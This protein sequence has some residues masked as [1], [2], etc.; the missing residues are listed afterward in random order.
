MQPSEIRA[1][2]KP[3]RVLP[4]ITVEDVARTVTLSRTLLEAGMPAVELTL[5]TPAA[6]EGI[7]A[8]KAEVPGLLIAAGTVTNGAELDRAMAAGAD[9]AVSPG[10]TS[11]LLQAARQS[12]VGL[13]PGVASPSD[14][15]LGLDYGLD[16]F[17]LFPAA[18]LGG[19]PM[20]KALGGP[21]PQVS[22]CP[23]GGLNPD[24]FRDYLALPNVIC[25]GGSWMV[26]PA[27]VAEGQWDRIAALAA[28][29]MATDNN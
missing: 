29:A 19:I 1:T 6:L 17:K 3:C 21:F 5:R 22:F 4:V 7:A 8:V 26:A 12:G 2:L 28:S 10:L 25:C 18:A 11:G 20:L 13:V 23:T 14:I 16:T 15:M 9:F 24:N 27:L